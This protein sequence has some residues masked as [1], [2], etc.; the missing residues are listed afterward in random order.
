MRTHFNSI[1]HI[2]REELKTISRDSGV[3][4]FFILLNI[5]YPIIYTYIYSNEVVREVPVAVVDNDYSSTSRDFIRKW[6]ASPNVEVVAKCANMQDAQRLLY[7]KKIYGI[8]EIPEQFGHEIARNEQAHVSLFTDMGGLLNYKAI[9]LSASDVSQLM[10][11]EI[12]VY[13]LEYASP[14]EQELTSTPVR[15]EEVKIFNP[16]SGY[17]SF[18][19]PAILI[20]VIQQ[21]L[22]LGVGTLTGTAR[23]RNKYG[24]L[25]P[26][27]HFHKNPV[28]IVIGKALAYI[29][30]YAFMLIWVYIVVPGIFNLT[31]IGPKLDLFLFL[32]PFLL[33]SV[34][35]AICFSF[36]CKEREMPFIIFVFTSVPLMF[37]S[38]ISWPIEAIPSYWV[39]FSKIFPSTFGIEGYTKISNMGAGLEEVRPIFYSLWV[40]T[41]IYFALACLLYYREIRKAKVLSKR[42]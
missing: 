39:T 35:M 29:S 6:D 5:G 1:Y 33:S 12:Q 14:K 16:Q 21:S 38:G 23:D 3:W 8:M 22:L 25:I 37:L 18:I 20:L 42:N 24:R 13:G 11:K 30:I 32:I 31:R 36:F 34:F 2:F 26:A 28:H 19:I 15:M 4:I 27:D 17:A 10:G 9:L 7:E 41:G 40:L